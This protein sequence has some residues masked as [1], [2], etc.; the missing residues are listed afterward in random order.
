MKEPDPYA[1]AW[2]IRI[3]VVLAIVGMILAF[4]GPR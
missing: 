3:A 1:P 2:P 4:C